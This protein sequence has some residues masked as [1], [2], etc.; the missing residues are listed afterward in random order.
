MVALMFLCYGMERLPI[1]CQRMSLKSNLKK[2]RQNDDHLN[3]IDQVVKDQLAACII[4]PVHNLEQ[5][6]AEHPDYAFLP[7]MGIFKPDRE[8]TKCR[9]VFFYQT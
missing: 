8:T 9:K 3:L 6:K 2:H 4:T 5:Y 7:H 1:F